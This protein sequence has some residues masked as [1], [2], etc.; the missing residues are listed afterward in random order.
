MARI[1]DK[2][3]IVRSPPSHLYVLHTICAARRSSTMMVAERAHS[4]TKMLPREDL[5]HVCAESVVCCKLGS[6]DRPETFRP[7]HLWPT[8]GVLSEIRP[9]GGCT[10][11]CVSA[12]AVAPVDG[13]Q[14]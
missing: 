1:L 8:V 3:I 14:G 6:R 13:H 2:S 11:R 10:A 12:S 7:H 5:R 9:N 4:V